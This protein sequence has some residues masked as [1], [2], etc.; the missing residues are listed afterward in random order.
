MVPKLASK[1]Y[2]L[3]KSWTKK[4]CYKD[5][6]YFDMNMTMFCFRTSIFFFLWRNE[7]FPLIWEHI[8]Y[9]SV[10]NFRNENRWCGQN[11]LHKIGGSEKNWFFKKDKNFH[12]SIFFPETETTL[13]TTLMCPLSI[14]WVYISVESQ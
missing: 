9:P 4:W 3:E 12:I 1:I 5:F 2:H 8:I 10:L 13:S 6:V 14:H 11:L 7:W